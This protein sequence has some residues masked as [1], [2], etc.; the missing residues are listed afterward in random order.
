VSATGRKKKSGPATERRE[1]D[2]YPTPA[3][4]VT[5]L[6][7]HVEL[8][9][10]TWLEP[11]AGDGAIIRA[12]RSV[13]DDVAWR[14]VE[15]RPEAASL[16]LRALDFDQNDRHNVLTDDFL[17]VEF[18]T[19]IGGAP[20]FD[21]A[22][23][24]PPFSLAAPFVLQAL[25]SAEHV[26]MLLRL[27]FLGSSND[28]RHLFDEAGVPDVYVLPERPSFT[29]EGTDACEYA[30]MRWTRGRKQRS[31]TRILFEKRQLPMFGGSP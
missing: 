27:N 4:C 15:I 26:V 7:Q 5:R 23:G 3:W 25:K 21:V 10:G 31:E 13:R 8:P 30:W 1:A 17:R 11:S 29:G 28:R 22:I 18:A 12:V 19:A 2:Y 20:A 16:I 14:A 24:N 6:L 9:G